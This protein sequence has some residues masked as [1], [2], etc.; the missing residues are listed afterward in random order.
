MLRKLAR[1][2]RVTVLGWH[3]NAAGGG[4]CAAAGPYLCLQA[5]DGVGREPRAGQT[6]AGDRGYRRHEESWPSAQQSKILLFMVRLF[7][8]WLQVTQI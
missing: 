6:A 5:G 7:I 1:W 2:C 4:S 3:R 8:K